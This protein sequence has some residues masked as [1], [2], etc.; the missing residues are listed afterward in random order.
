MHACFS[1]VCWL[2]L[3]EL[4]SQLCFILKGFNLEEEGIAKHTFDNVDLVLKYSCVLDF[5]FFF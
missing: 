4:S 5:F 3:A 2:L 1:H